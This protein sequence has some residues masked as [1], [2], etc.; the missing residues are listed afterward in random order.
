M[1]GY[2]NVYFQILHIFGS[3]KN[4]PTDVSKDDFVSTADTD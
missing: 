2:F 1:T 3:Q 4:H